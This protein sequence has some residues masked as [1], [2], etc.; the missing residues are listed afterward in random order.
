LRRENAL[1]SI[2]FSN[3]DFAK[4][5]FNLLCYNQSSRD[6]ITSRAQREVIDLTADSESDDDGPPAVVVSNG[7]PHKGPTEL[8]DEDDSDSD[9][10]GDRSSSIPIPSPT[11]FHLNALEEGIGEDRTLGE[12]VL[13]QS[14]SSLGAV[15]LSSLNSSVRELQYRYQPRQNFKTQTRHHSSPIR[16]PSSRGKLLS[17]KP[18]GVQVVAIPKA[19]YNQARRILVPISAGLPLVAVS[20]RADLQFFD[21][22]N[23]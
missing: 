21:R 9:T 13:E 4:Q 23:R 16:E 14:S 22:K 15:D 10:E 7:D 1:A 3:V 6:P 5:A 11:G 19:A 20:M 8:S 17:K 2:T 12:Y 18:A